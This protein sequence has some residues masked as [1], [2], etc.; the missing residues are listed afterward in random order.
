M[1]PADDD[2][3][4]DVDALVQYYE[5]INDRWLEN[6]PA[7]RDYMILTLDP[8]IHSIFQPDLRT[9][10]S[11]QEIDVCMRRHRW[12]VT[13]LM[14]KTLLMHAFNVVSER[15]YVAQGNGKK[16]RIWGFWGIKI[17]E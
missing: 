14:M 6:V 10:T 9:F 7:W 1:L 13:P 5:G 4:I 12:P 15:G 16:I 17:I 11:L 8:Y 3:P 2:A